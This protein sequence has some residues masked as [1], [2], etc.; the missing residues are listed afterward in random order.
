MIRAA[1]ALFGLLFGLA[2]AGESSAQTTTRSLSLHHDGPKGPV[3]AP[4]GRFG[5]LGEPLA[6]MDWLCVGVSSDLGPT[7]SVRLTDLD[8]TNERGERLGSFVSKSGTWHELRAFHVRAASG[9]PEV[10]RYC[11]PVRPREDS[12]TSVRFV[13][14]DAH[15]KRLEKVVLGIRGERNG[16][17]DPNGR[18]SAC[19]ELSP[20]RATFT[21][22]ASATAFSSIAVAYARAADL[23]GPAIGTQA[24]VLLQMPLL[25]VSAGSTRHFALELDAGVSIP[26]VLAATDARP[27]FGL[28]AFW[29]QCLVARFAVVPR[30][31]VGVSLDAMVDGRV[32]GSRIE[33]PAPRAVGSWFVSLGFGAR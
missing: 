28:G 6:Y 3:V 7:L 1:S 4:L 18:P 14:D 12:E 10:F 25:V 26:L 20:T 22:G 5:T 11:T 31:C 27:G 13:A 16:C 2:L 21:Y 9:T 24:R 32:T 17:E 29:S 8:V 19:G 15:T 30:A 23:T 33:D